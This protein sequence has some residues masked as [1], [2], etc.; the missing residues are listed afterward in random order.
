MYF[1]FGKLS[2]TNVIAALNFM[3]LKQ[4]QTHTIYNTEHYTCQSHH[5]KINANKV[6]IK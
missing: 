4:W 5:D 2:V 1:C 3:S 6:E